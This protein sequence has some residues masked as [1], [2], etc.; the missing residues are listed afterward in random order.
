[1]PLTL[2]RSLLVVLVPGIVALAPWLLWLVRDYAS[3][4][5][6]YREFPQAVA[7]AAFAA[8]VVFG[9]TVE[10]LNSYLE[11]LWDAERETQW[12]VRAN[13]YDYLARSF[14]HEPVGY[15][16]LSR[17][18]TTM[19]FELGM[20]WAIA[21]AGLGVMM[22]I[23]TS[24]VVSLFGLG[25]AAAAAILAPWLAVT[26][27]KDTHEVLCRVRFELNRRLPPIASAVGPPAPK[28]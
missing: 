25:V 14:D 2:T 21:I 6:L 18:I 16:Y 3:I 23:S 19:Y 7:A 22:F 12:A 27:A 20:A 24:P 26:A 28:S 17:M 1:M 15:T 9:T 11:D 10:S 8:V 5:E 4:A 13:W